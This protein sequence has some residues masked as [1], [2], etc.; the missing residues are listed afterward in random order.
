MKL[1]DGLQWVGTFFILAMYIISNFFKGEDDLRNSV[2]LVGAI[3]FFAW[4]YRVANKPQMLVNL[5][6]IA[7]CMGGLVTSFISRGYL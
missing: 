3:C 1:N 6:A 4:G 2:A 7:A 5:V